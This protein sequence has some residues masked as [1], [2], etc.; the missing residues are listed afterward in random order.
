MRVPSN[1]SNNLTKYTCKE[2]QHRRS[3]QSLLN[4]HPAATCTP[5]TRSIRA[6]T[7]CRQPMPPSVLLRKKMS[8]GT[9]EEG[10]EWAQEEVQ[11]E[12]KIKKSRNLLKNI[13]PLD[14]CILDQ[15]LNSN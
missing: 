2:E 1:H 14:L 11:Q 5:S 6:Q 13:F 8:S 10:V 12:I 4:V 15:P 9:L 3:F 7:Q